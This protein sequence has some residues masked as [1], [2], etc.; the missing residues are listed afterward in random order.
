MI[1]TLSVL[2]HTSVQEEHWVEKS[3]SNLNEFVVMNVCD[4]LFGGVPGPG[5]V[6]RS[7][8]ERTQ[9]L[10]IQISLLFNQNEYTD[11]IPR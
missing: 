4:V 5:V 9:G 11:V 7:R 10:S 6:L 3:G 1:K 2:W 8:I